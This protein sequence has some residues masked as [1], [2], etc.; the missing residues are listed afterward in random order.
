MPCFLAVGKPK[1]DAVRNKQKEYSL[2]ER[3]HNNVWE[4]SFTEKNI[5]F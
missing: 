4:K 5:L 1:E 3:V 2:Q